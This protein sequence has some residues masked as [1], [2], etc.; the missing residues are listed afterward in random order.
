MTVRCQ[1][2]ADELALASK[3]VVQRS[4][5]G[6]Q[7]SLALRLPARLEG[8]EQ[9]FRLQRSQNRRAKF[10]SLC[11]QAADKKNYFRSESMENKNG[12]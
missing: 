2:A 7:A 6:G 8:K 12:F 11:R 1:Q 10:D 5:D 4:T 9:A 3:L